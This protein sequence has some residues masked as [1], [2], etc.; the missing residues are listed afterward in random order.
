MISKMYLIALAICLVIGGFVGWSLKPDK[1]IKSIIDEYQNRIAFLKDSLD[2]VI[3]EQLKEIDS[4]K[5][6][7]PKIVYKYKVKEAS[8]DSSIA[9]DSTQSI[10]EYRS[11]LASLGTKPDDTKQ[12]TYRE[13][14]FGAKYF[15]QLK[16]SI[17]LMLVKDL[18]NQKQS[19]INKQLQSKV[20]ILMDENEL[21]KLKECDPPGFFYK[22]FIPY[23]GI[24]LSYNGK[25]VE[26]ALQLGFGV[27]IN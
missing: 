8:I 12:L 25:T 9:A 17:D 6:L 24:G 14:G 27:R 3:S 7:E 26:P 22:R 5:S 13:I 16:G 11:G 19:L 23:L 4:L 15:N 2:N 1:D 21:L 18:V 10:T 20:D